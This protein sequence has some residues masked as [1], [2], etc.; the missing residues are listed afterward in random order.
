MSTRRGQWIARRGQADVA[1]AIDQVIDQQPQPGELVQEVADELIE[2]SPYQARQSLDESS[3]ED[4]AQ[5]MCE[6][7]FQ[8]VLIVRPHG[9][10]AQRRRGSFQL[11]YGHRR[12]AAWRRVCAE[13][14]EPCRLPVLVREVSEERLLTIGA[15]ENLQRKDLD[16]VEEAQLVAWH[17]RM[18]FD[19]NQAEIGAMLGKS[20]DWVSVRSR[21]HKLPDALKERLHQRPRA[22]KQ[23]LELG[24]L[25]NQQPQMATNLAHRVVDEHL[26][27][28]ALRTFIANLLAGEPPTV[29]RQERSNHRAGAAP[30]RNITNK[31]SPGAM[32][33]VDQ[34]PSSI[35][36]SESA[37][38]ADDMTIAASTLQDERSDPDSSHSLSLDAVAGALAALASQA[39]E[40]S[41]DS[42]TLQHVEIAEQALLLIHRAAVRRM[43]PSSVVSRSHSYRLLNTELSDLVLLLRQHRTALA[44]LHPTQ[45]K[46][47]ALTLVLCRVPTNARP[48]GSPPEGTLLFVATL[49]GG[50]AIVPARHND[51]R[52]WARRQLKLSQQE[53]G[54]TLALLRDL[55]EI[56]LED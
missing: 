46:G 50:S 17:E 27:V 3:L 29:N 26:T 45:G 52:D 32:S 34:P 49:A 15:Q 38:L 5:G 21:I 48:V 24:L 16:P 2:D 41:G 9:D 7:G 14:G 20:S 13:R 40:I 1:A 33:G 12:R 36:P 42:S 39:D 51:L 8:G 55:Q 6:V 44:V 28:E 31:V 11:V 25:Y 19:K 47:Q 53:A 35:A 37:T 54:M 56:F 30:V 4:L 23:M 43:L 22:I 10:L 18:F